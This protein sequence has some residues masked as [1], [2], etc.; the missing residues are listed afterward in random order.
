MSG[1]KMFFAICLGIVFLAGCGRAVE[2][3]DTNKVVDLSGYWNDTDS[4]LT[5][6]EMVKDCLNRPWLTVF[7]TE[8]KKEPVVI[9][10][11]VVNR[12]HEHIDSLVFTKDLERE[13]INSALVKFVASR[14]ERE[15]IRAERADQAAGNTEASTIK[16]KGHETGADFMLQGTVNSVKDA[17]R[18]K[19]VILYQVDL[20]LIDLNSNQKVWIGQKE[21]KKFVK[22]GKIRF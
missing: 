19:Y 17:I 22:S 20:E 10:G 18:G 2:R 6:Q 5:A 16:P 13:L 3:I 14:D 1:L 11:S 12:S 15:E 8:K 4:R 7:K 9:V 21:I